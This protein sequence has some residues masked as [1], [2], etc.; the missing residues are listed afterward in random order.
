MPPTR[1]RNRADSSF[2]RELLRD[3]PGRWSHQEGTV[4]KVT[5]GGALTTLY[6]FTDGAD[7][8]DPVGDLIQAPD[9]NLYGTTFVGPNG[10]GTVFKI[11]PGGALTTLYAFCPLSGNCVDGAGPEAGLT[12]ATDGNFY[13]TTAGGGANG[14]NG[15]VFKVTPGG[16][17]HNTVQLL[18]PGRLR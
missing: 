6:S 13:G 9:G 7:G 11:I 10:E 16:H 14:S 18:C 2:R 8:A 12:Q 15:T 1:R 4:F 5:P 17:I 3:N